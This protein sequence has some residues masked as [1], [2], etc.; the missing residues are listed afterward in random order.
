M[1]AYCIHDPTHPFTHTAAW[2]LVFTRSK[3]WKRSVEHVPLKE[4]ARKDFTTG[5]W[6][7]MCIIIFFIHPDRNCQLKKKFNE[8]F[9][10][11]ISLYGMGDQCRS[12]SAHI[13]MPFDQ[14][15]HCSLLLDSL[16]Y[17]WPK[18]EQCRSRSDE[19]YVPADLDLH[20]HWSHVR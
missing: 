4:P 17:F 8:P 10:P 19:M 5:D 13:S 12:R 9:P 20:V 11:Y 1:L 14:A 6:K 3:G 15:L 7:K 2:I 18:S 16:G